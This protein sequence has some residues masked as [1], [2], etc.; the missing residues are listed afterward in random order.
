[1]SGTDFVGPADLEPSLVALAALAL[2][3]ST[4]PEVLA[5]PWDIRDG[6]TP[7]LAARVEY[8]LSWH[9]H[10]HNA[11][12]NFIRGLPTSVTVDGRPVSLA[13]LAISDNVIAARPMGQRK[14]ARYLRDGTHIHLWTDGEHFGVVHDDPR[15]KEFSTTAEQGGLTTPLPGVVVAVA[16]K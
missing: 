12:I 8:T 13:D 15:L 14:H 4:P 7:N 3:A 1:E 6:F 10:E 11:G 16:A 5:S 9:G 2:H